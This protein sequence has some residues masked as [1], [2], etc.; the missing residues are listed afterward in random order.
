[1]DVSCSI[2]TIPHF[3]RYVHVR[4]NI[5]VL[6]PFGHLCPINA[7]DSPCPI[8][9][10]P[11][12]LPARGQQWRVLAPLQL[13]QTCWPRVRKSLPDNALSKPQKFF[14]KSFN[15]PLKSWYSSWHSGVRTA[16]C[17]QEGS[18]AASV[19][20]SSQISMTA[21]KDPLLL[22]LEPLHYGAAVMGSWY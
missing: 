1:M 18:A 3:V 15:K 13:W 19:D 21:V 9:F 12:F 16:W 5:R 2:K 22:V 17:D 20:Q 6:V 11:I 4:H 14:Q 8:C 7:F 10:Y